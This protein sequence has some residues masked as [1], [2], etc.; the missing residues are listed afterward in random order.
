MVQ[1]L[2]CVECGNSVSDTA[3]TCPHCKARDY[4]GLSCTVCLQ[5][6]K[7]SEV[8]ME[9]GPMD[10]TMFFHP[11]CFTQVRNAPRPCGSCGV[12]VVDASVKECPHCGSDLARRLCNFCGQPY[13]PH[14]EDYDDRIQE[15]VVGGVSVFED[16]VLKGQGHRICAEARGGK[17]RETLYEP[18]YRALEAGQWQEADRATDQL[19]RYFASRSSVGNFPVAELK[20]IDELWVRY[21]KGKF[22]FSV[23]SRL[24]QEVG[25]TLGEDEPRVY[26][27]FALRVG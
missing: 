13:S 2:Q 14:I 3:E 5:P 18:L 22:G 1:L 11:D 15:V 12:F 25:G 21:S 16:V 4:R 27:E 17:P 6:A 26:G 10:T 19:I 20:Q 23:Q 9:P 8:R 7:P 24:W